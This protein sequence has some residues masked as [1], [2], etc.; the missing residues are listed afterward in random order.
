MSRF[1]IDYLRELEGLTQISR[2]DQQRG[3]RQH[4]SILLPRLKASAR[5]DFEAILEQRQL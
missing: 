2:A 3:I 1:W 5:R 4:L